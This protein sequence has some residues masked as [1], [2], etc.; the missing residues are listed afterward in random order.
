MAPPIS[1]GS[2]ELA[3]TVEAPARARAFLRTTMQTWALDG[4]GE[5]T[6]L[7]TSELVTNVVRHVGSSM[8]VRIT[9]R[10]SMVCVEVDDAS[11]QPPVLAPADSLGERGRGLILVD[12]LASN[13]GTRPSDSG[14]TV[15]FE[16][17]A[18]SATRAIY[19]AGR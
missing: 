12:A 19:G 11:T 5:L 17:E 7:L 4:L 9:R 16:V 1:S 14:K 2:L 18:A 3:P 6:E 15:W 8:T 10:A 13:W